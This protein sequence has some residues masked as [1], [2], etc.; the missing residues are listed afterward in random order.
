MKNG[1][2]T[3]DPTRDGDER[4]RRLALAALAFAIAAPLAYLAQRLLDQALA[5]ET[6][7]L[8]MIRQGRA[9]YPW[10]AA[11]AAFWGGLGA[12][13]AFAVARPA[14]PGS[15]RLERY[16]VPAACALGVLVLVLAWVF[17]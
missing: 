4:R 10:R 14:R 12:I 17:P 2:L 16:A 1:D 9:A 6:D 3:R 8:S 13:V 15:E 11:T 5:G 7:A